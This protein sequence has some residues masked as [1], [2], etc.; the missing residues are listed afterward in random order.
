[1]TQDEAI[2][3]DLGTSV[4]YLGQRAVITRVYRYQGV[5]RNAYRVSYHVRTEDGTDY[6][7][8][9]SRLLTIPA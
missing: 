3:S 8:L 7:H 5:G 1:M 2:R 9:D 4:E 6:R